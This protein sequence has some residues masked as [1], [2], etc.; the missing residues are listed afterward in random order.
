MNHHSRDRTGKVYK[1]PAGRG[2]ARGGVSN[3]ARRATRESLGTKRDDYDKL[4]RRIVYLRPQTVD[5]K[6]LC[7]LCGQR[8]GRLC[9]PCDCP[10]QHRVRDVRRSDLLRFIHRCREEYGADH[11][12]YVGGRTLRAVQSVADESLP[13][14]PFKVP[15]DLGY[16]LAFEIHAP[17]WGFFAL[18]TCE[19]IYD[20]DEACPDVRPPVVA[21]GSGTFAPK[22]REFEREIGTPRIILETKRDPRFKDDE[23]EDKARKQKPSQRKNEPL[24][25]YE[26]RVRQWEREEVKR[27]EA[28][29]ARRRQGDTLVIQE[30]GKPAQARRFEACIADTMRCSACFVRHDENGPR[31]G[32]GVEGILF[33]RSEAVLCSVCHKP[34]ANASVD[35]DGT[36]HG[37]QTCLCSNSAPW[38]LTQG[39]RKILKE[40]TAREEEIRA[41]R[42]PDAL[43]R[44]E[45]ALWGDSLDGEERKEFQGGARRGIKPL[46]V[47]V[48]C[49]NRPHHC[50]C[51]E[52]QSLREEGK[53]ERAVRAEQIGRRAGPKGESSGRRRNKRAGTEAQVKEDN[54]KIRAS[55][56][57]ESEEMIEARALA[58]ERAAREQ[59][60]IYP[61]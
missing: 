11:V 39:A 35:D 6:A 56:G 18:R 59:G 28:L 25:M 13:A 8:A 49:G 24:W 16:P 50:P 4:V 14:E 19:D 54:A 10:I 46:L 47:C 55:L 3:P 2:L 48:V 32:C 41:E 51:G 5:E 34:Y 45:V 58:I 44:D 1:K 15:E 7:L 20:R 17:D 30:E 31:C 61:H 22:H 21:T 57:A 36:L 38:L 52:T 9:A 40:G 26:K 60:R 33:K 37:E 43:E 53:L 23:I 27:R 12:L 42:E 29:R